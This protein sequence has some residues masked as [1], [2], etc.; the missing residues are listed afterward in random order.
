MSR[1][2]SRAHKRREGIMLLFMVKISCGRGKRE[3][4]PLRPSGTKKKKTTV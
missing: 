1:L 3:L 2:E 4:E